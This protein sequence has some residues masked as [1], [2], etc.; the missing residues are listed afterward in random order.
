MPC[1]KSFVTAVVRRCLK[2]VRDSSEVLLP[3]LRGTAAALSEVAD[4]LK[5]E[6]QDFR[7]PLQVGRRG[8]EA[9]EMPIYRRSIRNLG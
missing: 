9:N 4:L 7:G 1:Y 6:L 5:T 3:A 8:F 2:R